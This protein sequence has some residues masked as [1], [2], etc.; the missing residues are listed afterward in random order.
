MPSVLRLDG[1]I[2]THWMMP[3]SVT[4]RPEL[5]RHHAAEPAVELTKDAA[6]DV[7]W[8]LHVVDKKSR[9]TVANAHAAEENKVE[10]W[11]RDDAL[12]AHPKRWQK[13]RESLRQ[14]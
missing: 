14:E 2:G 12:V 8:N 1:G 3:D 7:I 10:T 11:I 5:T 13:L 6:L 4:I 9:R